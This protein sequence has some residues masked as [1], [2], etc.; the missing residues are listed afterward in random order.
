MRL[1]AQFKVLFTKE[2]GDKVDLIR[3]AADDAYAKL[4]LTRA[5]SSND[6]ALLV[7]TMQLMQARGLMAKS[8]TEPKEADDKINRKY[9]GRLR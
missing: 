6:E 8:T 7:I 1:I 3:F 2:F 4:L 5:S 9:T